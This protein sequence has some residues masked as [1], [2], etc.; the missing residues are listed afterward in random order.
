MRHI[1]K[2][3][4]VRVEKADQVQD[5]ICAVVT[6]LAAVLQAFGGE[7]PIA[8]YIDSKCSFEVPGA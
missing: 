8:N 3:S 4:S 5:A 7:S 6:V 2:I 1:Q